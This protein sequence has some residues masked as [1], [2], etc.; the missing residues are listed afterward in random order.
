M[1]NN[2]QIT[3]HSITKIDRLTTMEIVYYTKEFDTLF[4]RVRGDNIYA[5]AEIACETMIKHKFA[6][7]DIVATDTHEVLMQL[8]QVTKKK[9]A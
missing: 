2:I 8:E 3:Y 7:A 9:G 5:V 6:A 4:Q 1:T